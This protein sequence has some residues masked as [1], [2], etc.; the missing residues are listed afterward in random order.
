MSV[1]AVAVRR[2]T[3]PAP[4]STEGSGRRALR[5]GLFAAVAAGAVFVLLQGLLGAYSLHV[6]RDAIA[7]R[8]DQGAL[9]ACL[10]HCWFQAIPEAIL[11]YAGFALAG[12]VIAAAGHRILFAL[13]ASMY[14][15]FGLPHGAYGLM[16]IGR[17]WQVPCYTRCPGAWFGYP[18]V[19]AATDLVLVLIPAFVVARSVRPQRWPGALTPS[20]VASL[21]LAVGLMVLTYRT[22]AVINRAPDVRVAWAVASLALVAGARRPWWPWAHWVWAAAAGGTLGEVWLTLI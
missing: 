21:G 16:A 4:A 18:P 22:T 10:S 1:A 11:I 15:L 12:V 17:Q 5:R 20:I 7:R 9:D 8:L 2:P 19:G 6:L 3:R 13:P 14:V